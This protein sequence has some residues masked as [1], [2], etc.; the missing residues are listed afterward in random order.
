V[1]ALQ[2]AITGPEIVRADGNH[3]YVVYPAG[4]GTA[5][6]TNALMAK[7]LGSRCTARNWNTVLKLRALADQAPS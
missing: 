3:A 4:I 5:R 7:H 2:A 6:L 1:K